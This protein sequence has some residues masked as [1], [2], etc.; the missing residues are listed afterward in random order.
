MKE[1]CSPLHFRLRHALAPGSRLRFIYDERPSA[2]H[3]PIERRNRL[4]AVFVFDFNEAKAT[5]TARLPV[6]NHTC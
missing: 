4:L 1:A 5:G 2:K 6:A 3:G